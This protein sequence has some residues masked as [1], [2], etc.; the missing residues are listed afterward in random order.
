MLNSCFNLL[1]YVLCQ[2]FSFAFVALPRICEITVNLTFSSFE[3]LSRYK[4]T[5]LLIMFAPVFVLHVASC[6]SLPT[7]RKLHRICISLLTAILGP[8]S[9][10]ANL[11]G[12]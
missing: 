2:C 5:D 8:L 11:N 9:E 6:F 12:V 10:V 7:A 1:M 3:K 4:G